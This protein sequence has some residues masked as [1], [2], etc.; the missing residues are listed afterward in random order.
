[1]KSL[2]I[3]AAAAALCCLNM[4]AQQQQQQ[5]KKVSILQIMNVKTGKTAVVKE[6]PGIIEAPNWTPDG[7][8]LVYNSN[9]KL[10]KIAVDGKSDPILIPTGEANNCNNDHVISKDGKQI[11]ISSSVIK[12]KSYSSV[13]YTVPFEGGEAK[14]ITP[15][16]MSYLHGWSPDLKT[17]AFCGS[18]NG[19]R[20]LDVYTI[21]VNGD[22]EKQLTTTDGL[23]DGPEYSP[24]GKQIWFNSVRT[25]LMQ[26]WLMNADGSNQ[27]QMTFDKDFNSW[28]A[29]ISP[30]GKLIVYI[31]YHKGD[32]EPG[33]HVADKNVVL[34]LMPAKGGTPKT[35]LQLFGGQGTLNVNSWA[36]DSKRF[37]FVSYRYEK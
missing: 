10:Y 15:D 23:D 22:N 24:D 26:I 28:F 6:F 8:W 4:N 35:I 37:A 27:T 18:R 11:G 20:Q 30:N 36:P 29:H 9:G 16:G 21:S 31:A 7:K 13:V 12:D 32:L 33:Q 17:L 19:A 14:R 5:Q 1:M 2:F 3:V 25:G 34:R